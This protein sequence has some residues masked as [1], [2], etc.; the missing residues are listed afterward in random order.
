MREKL[1]SSF[2][3]LAKREKTIEQLE[4]NIASIKIERMKW[5]DLFQKLRKSKLTTDGAKSDK[6]SGAV[7][8]NDTI[9]KN[10]SSDVQCIFRRHFVTEGLA[11]FKC[12][13]N[14]RGSYNVTEG[15]VI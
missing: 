3:E 14:Q 13:S 4:N 12:F 10:V 6:P 9:G 11:S 2:A 5:H 8:N 15:E 7:T 1:Q